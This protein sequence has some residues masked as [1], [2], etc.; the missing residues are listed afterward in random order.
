MGC[1][2]CRLRPETGKFFAN[3]YDGYDS[4]TGYGHCYSL[5]L[6]GYRGWQLARP[7]ADNTEFAQPCS[8][9]QRYAPWAR[10]ESSSLA[11]P[12][13]TT[14]RGCAFRTTRVAARNRSHQGSTRKVS[15][16]VWIFSQF[17]FYVRM[18]VLC[19]H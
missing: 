7:P 18:G 12:S 4:R 8:S 3:T 2:P 5:S 14:T 16:G 17:K 9:T 15:E 6:K 1:H 11:T 19:A 10:S 13:A